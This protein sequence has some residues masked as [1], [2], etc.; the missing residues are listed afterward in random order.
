MS[1]PAFWLFPVTMALVVFGLA[2]IVQWDKR[3]R[4]R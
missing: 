1:Y 2:G 4:G 3:R